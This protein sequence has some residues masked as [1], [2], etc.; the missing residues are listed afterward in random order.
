M[1]KIGLILVLLLASLNAPAQTDDSAAKEKP[2][3]EQKLLE[4]ILTDAKSLR[5]PENRAMVFARAGNWY[6]QADEK[7]ARK[8]FQDAVGDLIAAQSEVQNDKNRQYFQGLLYGQSPR[9]D[10]I[11]TISSRDAELALEYLA[12]SRPASIAEIIQNPNADQNSTVW[13]YAR[14]EIAV[15]Q[16]LL[17]LAAEQNPQTAIKRVRESLKKGVSYETIALLKKI[18]TKDAPAAD[19]LARELAENFL[20]TDF[21][22]NYQTSETVGQFINEMGR[23]RTKDE[24]A[25]QIPEDL[26]RRLV[27]KILDGWLDTKTVQPYG[28]WNCLAIVEKLFPERAARLKKKVEA[29]NNSSQTEE[30]VEYSKLVSGDTP[31][32]E[33][34]VRVEKLQTSSYRNEVYR[35]A[36]QKLAQ[37]GSIAQAERIMQTNVSGEQAEYYLSTFYVNLSYQFANQGKFDEANN[38]VNQ[39]PDE[40]QRLSALINLANIVNQKN[41]KEN[42]KAAENILNQARALIPDM[43]ETVNEFNAALS[44]ATAYAPFDAAQSFQLVESLLPS[45]NEII[46]ANFV[47][48]KFRSYGGTRRNEMQIPISNNIGTYNLEGVLRVL[49]D[50]DFD[51]TLQIAG[52]FNRPEARVWLEMQLIDDN[53]AI[54]ANLPINSRQMIID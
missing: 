39:I 18:Y 33:M 31:P 41:P 42:A 2:A 51:R 53:P 7:K 54:I 21:S 10:I 14:N 37:N 3:R 48:M 1:R 24:K 4:Q 52:S 47:V 22:K 36:A 26:L 46:Q 40:N 5:L 11:N 32:E 16:R 17:G 15:E 23:E 19:D 49:K 45:M 25:L 13:Q 30:S 34:M 38:Y 35:A 50:K 28:Y 9:L 12:K 8:L 20:Q 44:L 43:P 27:A 6:W 29:L